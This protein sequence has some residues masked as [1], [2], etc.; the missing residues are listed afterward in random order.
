[1]ATI[2]TGEQMATKKKVAK[3]AVRTK[4][5]E[6]LIGVEGSVPD[7]THISITKNGGAYWKSVDKKLQ[8]EIYFL[9]D[10]FDASIVTG[11]ITGRTK[12]LN[13]H[14]RVAAGDQF[15][16]HVEGPRRLRKGQVKI[17]SAGGIII[18]A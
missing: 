17:S 4:H 8:W 18:D 11:T 15:T 3:K 6:I 12:N 16:Y 13:L 1:V 5:L 7:T 14:K 9:G 10:P 2:T